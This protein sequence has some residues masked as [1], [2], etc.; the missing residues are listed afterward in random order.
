MHVT[1]IKIPTAEC[2]HNYKRV[3]A[4]MTVYVM[5]DINIGAAISQALNISHDKVKDAVCPKAKRKT[6]ACTASS[7]P[8]N[9]KSS[10]TVRCSCLLLLNQ[11]Q[12]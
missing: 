5:E 11:G 7:L 9:V 8:V 10:S 3:P 4:L 6:S 1:P 2:T 12:R